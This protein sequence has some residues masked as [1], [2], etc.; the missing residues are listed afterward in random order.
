MRVRAGTA[1]WVNK[2]GWRPLAVSAEPL[3]ASCQF[4]IRSSPGWPL[5]LTP[6][7][8]TIQNLENNVKLN[9]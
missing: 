4:E 5:G 7:Y 3:A 6:G 8:R 2:A 9:K 1:S